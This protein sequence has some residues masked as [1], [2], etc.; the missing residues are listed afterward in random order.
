M[1]RSEVRTIRED[2]PLAEFRGQ[3]P[4]GSTQRVVVLDAADR[5]AGIVLVPEAYAPDLVEAKKATRVSDLLHYRNDM[6]LPAMNV[7]QAI[8]EFDRT[9]SE[10]L[11]VV[12]DP[13]E[14]R[15]IGL[16][17]ESHAM[18]RYSEELDKARKNLAG[19]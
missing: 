18:R 2:M 11:V 9:E 1:M 4:I 7:K 6:L 15:V 10:A 13:V 19:E 5:Y 12:Q 8:A 17:T 16:L 14:R 3:F